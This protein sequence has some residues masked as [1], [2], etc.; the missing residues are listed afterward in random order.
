MCS[1]SELEG[2]PSLQNSLELAISNFTQIPAYGRKEILVLF[3][4]LTNSDPGDIF[5]TIARLEKMEVQVNTI[6][7][8]AAIHVL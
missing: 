3:S 2:N 1:F 5:K 7:L 8:S 4:S 6:S